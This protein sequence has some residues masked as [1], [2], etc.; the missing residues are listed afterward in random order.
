MITFKVLLFFFLGG[1]AVGEF[2]ICL[3][4][5][6]VKL[7]TGFEALVPPVKKS[8]LV[9]VLSFRMEPPLFRCLKVQ[10]LALFS[11]TCKADSL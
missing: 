1:G 5:L 11:D 6:V 8:H 3:I 7:L 2:L 9:S 10:G 4:V